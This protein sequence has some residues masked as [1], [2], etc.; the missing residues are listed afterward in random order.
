MVDFLI[1]DGVSVLF[2][3]FNGLLNNG[4][5]LDFTSR[6]KGVVDSYGGGDGSR[7]G[8]GGGGSIGHGGVDSTV[9]SSMSIGKSSSIDSSMGKSTVDNSRVGNGQNGGENK[10]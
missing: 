2:N 1:T 7:S 8:D 4:G 6:G 3:G 10:L 5:F 9:V